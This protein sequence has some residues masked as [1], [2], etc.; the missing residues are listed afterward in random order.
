METRVTLPFADGT[1]EFWLPMPRVIAAERE[2]ARR[3]ADGVSQPRSI[4]AV[5][6]D[7]GSYIGDAMGEVVLAG[8]SPARLTEAH[9]IIR[10]ALIGGNMARVGGQEIAVPDF[11]A[12]ELVETYCYP[13]RPAMHD[14][15]LAWHILR[16]AIYGIEGS[17][18]NDADASN[19][20]PS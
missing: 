14:F 19:P 2:M 18:K 5:F 6:S 17:K 20:N 3:D 4:L 8:P 15:G 11:L 16:A 12:I 10:N 9:A 1:Y 7:I 13:A